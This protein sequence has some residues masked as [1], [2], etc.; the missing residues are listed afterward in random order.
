ME[1]RELFI[2]ENFNIVEVRHDTERAG[3]LHASGMVV[4]SEGVSDV[5]VAGSVTS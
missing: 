1:A 5:I 2:G 4:T 3:F